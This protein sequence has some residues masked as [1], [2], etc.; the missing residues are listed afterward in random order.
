[1]K[2]LQS[3]QR[4]KKL[5][6]SVPV[7][8]LMLIPT[9]FLVRGAVSIMS[10]SYESAETLQ[11]LER[12][13]VVLSQRQVELKAGIE[14]LESGEG[15]EDEIRSKFNVALEGEQVAIILEEKPVTPDAEEESRPWYQ[16]WWSAIMGQ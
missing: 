16:K 9:F 14:K 12:E 1:M 10:K 11:E 7:L 5:L 3:K 8:I 15:L 13:A 2:E 6:G 4:F